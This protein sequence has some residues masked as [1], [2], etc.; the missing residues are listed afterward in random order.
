MRFVRSSKTDHP[1]R[2]STDSRCKRILS[3][4]YYSMTLMMEISSDIRLFLEVYVRE[5][6]SIVTAAKG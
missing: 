3:L 2:L 6:I 1:T 4:P 5:V